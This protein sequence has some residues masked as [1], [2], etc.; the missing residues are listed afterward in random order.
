[1]F[2]RVGIGLMFT[3]IKRALH[4][5]GTDFDVWFHEQSLHDSGAVD[6]AVAR[7]KDTGNLYFADGAWWLR[8]TEFGDDKDRPVIKSDGR[9]AYIAGDLAYFLDKRARGF[10]L[11]IYMLGADHHG[12]IARLKAAAAAFGD[13]PAVVEVLIGQMV[14]LVRDGTPIRMS[15]RA[16]TVVTMDDLVG[17]VGVDAARYTLIRSSVDS[18]LDVDLDLVTRQSNDNPVFYVQYAHARLASLARNAADLGVTVPDAPDFGLLE[19]PREGDLI[20]TLGEFPAVVGQRGRAARAAPGGPLPGV[21]GQRVPQVL[22]HLPGA[23]DGRRAHH[24]AAPGPAR[25]VRGRPPGAGQRP[26]PARRQRPGTH[27]TA[28]DVEDSSEGTPRRAAAR[29]HPGAA[30]DRRP[31]PARRRRARRAG[32]RG[33]AA[34]RRPRPATARSSWPASTCGSWPSASAPR[35]S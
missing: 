14:N 10:D 30:G 23:A 25:A 4:E 33:L 9:P 6:A 1:M 12:Y 19:H 8:S 17:A 35:C 13:D 21:A 7:L 34:A 29:R 28:A 15:K 31:A 2:R 22:R 32:P 26:G 24:R 5:F 27:V 20:R 3:E 11:C 18:T 16:G